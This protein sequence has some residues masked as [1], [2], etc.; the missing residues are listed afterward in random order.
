[1]LQAFSVTSIQ[2]TSKRVG[3]V[4]GDSDDHCPYKLL[5]RQPTWRY[6]N[7]GQSL[8]RFGYDVRRL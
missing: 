3:C 6:G 1:M 5:I 7:M 2:E 4:V 8:Y